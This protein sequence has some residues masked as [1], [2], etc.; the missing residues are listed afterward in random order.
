MLIDYKKKI[1]GSP[2][3][4]VYELTPVNVNVYGMYIYNIVVYVQMF[5]IKCDT[6]TVFKGFGSGININQI[7]IEEPL[8]R[9]LFQT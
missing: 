6:S 7:K 3:K 9:G 5:V 1:A 2:I 4:Y 8:K